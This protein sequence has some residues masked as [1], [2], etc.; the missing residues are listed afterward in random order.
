MTNILHC[1]SLCVKRISPEEKCHKVKN[2]SCPGSSGIVVWEYE[3]ECCTVIR[4][5]LRH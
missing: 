4:R 3:E 2:K 5:R 1:R